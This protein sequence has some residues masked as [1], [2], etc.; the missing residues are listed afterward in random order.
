MDLGELRRGYSGKFVAIPG[1]EKVV[2]SGD[3]CNGVFGKVAKPKMS[4]LSELS[5]RFAR[6]SGGPPV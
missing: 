5:I 3:T 1:D 2:A 4:N 6:P